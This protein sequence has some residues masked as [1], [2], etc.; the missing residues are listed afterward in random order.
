[1]MTVDELRKCKSVT[2]DVFNCARC[3]KDHKDLE[4][5]KL[6]RQLDMSHWALCPET[7]EPILLQFH[8]VD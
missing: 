7:Q 4:F 8:E 3:G 1:M 2:V 6:T 5:W